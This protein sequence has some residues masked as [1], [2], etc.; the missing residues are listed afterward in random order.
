[1]AIEAVMIN[2]SNIM[3]VIVGN[4]GIIE[5]TESTLIEGVKTSEL[6]FKEISTSFNASPVEPMAVTVKVTVAMVP[7]PVN[8]GVLEPIEVANRWYVADDCEASLSTISIG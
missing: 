8:A 2:N 6:P 3:I 4:S 7:L 5:L 1:M